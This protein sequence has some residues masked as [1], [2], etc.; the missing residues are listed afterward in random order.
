MISFRVYGWR[1]EISQDDFD[2]VFETPW[3]M[4]AF[5]RRAY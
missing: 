2:F 5:A 4:F 1:G 3:L